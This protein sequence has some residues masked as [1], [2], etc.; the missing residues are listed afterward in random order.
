MQI[1]KIVAENQFS[2][3]FVTGGCFGVFALAA[4]VRGAMGA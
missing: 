3:G 1:R 4:I 2:M